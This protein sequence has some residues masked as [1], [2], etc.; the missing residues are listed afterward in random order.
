M[1]GSYIRMLR[2]WQ[3][4]KNAFVVIPL[5][6]GT[7][8]YDRYTFCVAEQIPNADFFPPK[9]MRCDDYL[10]I[11]LAL[12]AF[13]SWSSALYVFNDLIDRKRDQTHERKRHRPIAS[14]EI[15]PFVAECI[16]ALLA[17]LPFAV[18]AFALLPSARWF[19]FAGLAFLANGVCYCLFFRS[20]VFLDVIS[21]A[22]GFVL[23]V[24]AGCVIIGV[25]PSSWILVCTFTL[26]LF[27]AFGKR[28]MECVSQNET[29]DYRPALASYSLSNVNIL[30]GITAAVCLVSYLLYT[31]DRDTIT[32]HGTRNLIYTVPFVFYG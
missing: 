9:V 7:M 25:D 13:C 6:F 5:L 17:A 28:K 26:A 20:M 11:L 32:M 3:W 1:L 24:V 22:I 30:L 18:L 23:R 31:L 27:L 12:L 4:T 10:L 8:P 19:M 16:T 15:K 21:I 2:P 29:S 14:G